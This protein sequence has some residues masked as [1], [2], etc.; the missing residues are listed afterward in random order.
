MKWNVTEVWRFSAYTYL[1]TPVEDCLVCGAVVWWR[2]FFPSTH[3]PLF[4]ILFIFFYLASFSFFHVTSTYFSYFR[5]TLFGSRVCPFFFKSSRPFKV[6]PHRTSY[7]WGLEMRFKQLGKCLPIYS[8]NCK[9]VKEFYRSNNKYTHR[10]SRIFWRY[11]KGHFRLLNVMASKFL[12][13]YNDQFLCWHYGPSTIAR[14]N[15]I[16]CLFLKN[17]LFYLVL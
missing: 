4:A 7:W 11:L 10:L 12:S 14:F 13:E 2:T 15:T 3:T 6:F 5:W 16:F 9:R 8:R 17:I 1:L